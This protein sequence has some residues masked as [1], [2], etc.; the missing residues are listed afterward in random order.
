VAS[1]INYQGQLTDQDTGNPL[2]GEYDM[3]FL[4]YN[5]LT[6]GSQVGTTVTRNNVA[7]TN[8][9]FNVKLD[10]NQADFNGQGLW[11][12]VMVEGETLGPRQEILPVPY[13]LSLKP[14]ATMSAP[15]DGA[16]LRAENTGSGTGIYGKSSDGRGVRGHSS[17]SY[18]GFFSSDNDHFDLALG[19]AVGRINTD[20]DDENS[21]LILSSNNDVTVR[22]DNDGGE[23]SKFRIKNS[24]GIDVCTVNEA[25]DLSIAAD[26][27]IF[28]SG[29]DFVK[30]LNTDSTRWSCQFNGGVKIWGGS[31]GTKSIYIPITVPGVLY[32]QKVTVEELTIYYSCQDG[33]SNYITSTFLDKQTDA[34]NYVNIVAD[35]TDRKSNTATS[36]TLT[37]TTNNVLS[38][39]QGILNLQLSL[40]FADD[41]NYIQIGGARLRLGH[42]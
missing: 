7:V 40:N 28:M 24:S 12:E 31:A 23:E 14:G 35:F 41:S 16:V 32:G 4:F 21:N 29:N 42:R 9:L 33:T 6:G 22:L 30:A 11:L 1:T 10:V 18:G 39:N 3:Q 34:N 27:Y 13:A 17:T 2:S 8:G 5:A 25:G 20:P 38:S 37:L 19:G 36:Y 26:S 15:L